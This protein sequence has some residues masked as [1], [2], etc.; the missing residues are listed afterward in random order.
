MTAARPKGL[1]V[2]RGAIPLVANKPLPLYGL[3][4]M[5]SAGISEVG[6]VATPTAGAAIRELIQDGAAAG[7]EVRLLR[8]AGPS[9]VASLAAAAS[10]VDQSPCVVQLR[11][12]LV[13]GDLAP[14]LDELTHDDLDALLLLDPT[15]PASE[16][17]T[18]LDDLRLLRMTG[19]SRHSGRLAGVHVLGP[20]TVRAA[21][22]GAGT[23]VDLLRRVLADGGRARARPFEGSWR[24][25]AR[26]EELL[27]ANRV[28]L[29]DLHPGPVQ[30]ELIDSRIQ[31]RVLIGQ[32][33]RLEATTV[34]GPAV[35]GS[36]V[37]LR[38]A[39]IGPY[40]SIGDGV[41][42][43]GSEVEHSVVLPGAVIKHLGGRLEASVVGRGAKVFRDFTLPRAMRLRIADGDEVCLA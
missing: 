37:Q 1:I 19:Q 24:P 22:G 12:G 11:D 34:R 42:I 38:H 43:E 7:L 28:V 20:R 16:D 35:I 18:G 36:H 5:R 17:V 40:T 2:A 26:H 31:G 25:V 23:L 10:F 39:Y 21:C 4:A 8:R 9:P 3:D 6:I 32:N 27:E 14:L 41:E 13:R 15:E 33:T 29:D 30:G